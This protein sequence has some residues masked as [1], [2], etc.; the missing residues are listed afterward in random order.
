MGG[1]RTKIILSALETPTVAIVL[2][3]SYLPEPAILAR[4]E[5]RGVALISV[6]GDTV[7]AADDL[8]RL[9]GRMRVRESAKI[10]LISQIIGRVPRPGPPPRRSRGMSVTT[11]LRYTSPHEVT[12]SW[13]AQAGE[14]TVRVAVD[15]A[16]GD[17]APGAVIDGAL[18]VAADHLHVVLVGDEA[19]IRPLLGSGHPHVSVVHAPD[20]IGYREEA[21]YAA[22]NK[23][24]S[25]IVVGLRLVRDGAAD[26][27][28]SAG[29]TG[30]VVAASVLH[31][32]RI[33]GVLRPAIC[34][35]MPCMPAPI[36]F[37][38]AGA[39]AECRPEHLL[40]FA[41]MGQAFAGEVMGLSEP[42]VGLLSI[43]EEP[44]K[45][46]P[47]VIEAHRLM[48]ADERVR[49]YGNVEGR[50]IMN[51]VVDVVVADG[52]TGNVALKTIEGSARAILSALRAT[53]DSSAA[54]K[55][56]GPAPAARPPQA[57]SR[58]GSRGV[59]RSSACGHERSHRD[60]A[61]QLEGGRD[62][63]RHPPGTPGSGER[64]AADNH[65]RAGGG[66]LAPNALCRLWR[67]SPGG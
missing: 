62:R 37:L 48:A 4:A 63:Q 2:T 41:V 44:T 34:T 39:N 28:V 46:T 40:Q 67:N 8:R 18:R 32:R 47:E 1:D 26:A 12:A 11:S 33:K 53:I 59:W 5:E 35:I 24:A 29:N 14:G 42:Q 61:R 15:A 57:Q 20:V 49:F 51:R 22:R 45:G 43:G 58:P 7:T 27:F 56:G 13:S 55:L 54:T 23:T 10:D 16:G 66:F 19:L 9:F 36:A 25:S 64:P 38:D 52:F 65:P 30:A 3:G 17:H 6:S 21:A 31:V 50:D 60:R